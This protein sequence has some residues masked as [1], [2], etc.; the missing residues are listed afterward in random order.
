VRE[1]PWFADYDDV[2]VAVAV[3]RLSGGALAILTGTRHD[4]LGY[5][6]R[7]E[8]FGMRDSVAVGVDARSPIR[9]LEPGV[10][11]PSVPTYADFMQRFQ[12]AYEAELA[13]FVTTVIEGGPSACTLHEA[14]A[15]LLVALAADRSKNERRP[16]APGEIAQTQVIAG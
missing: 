7:L 5:D 8:A 14:R 9:S 2:D 3:L 6:V 11:Q 15:A 12:P 4:A 10:A 13:A 16:V 1:T